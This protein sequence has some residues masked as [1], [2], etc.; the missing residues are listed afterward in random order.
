MLGACE[1]C[2]GAFTVEDG[3]EDAPLLTRF[4]REC[5]L[6][7]LE[8]MY[9]AAV[10]AIL[11]WLRKQGHERCWYY[12]DIFKEVMKAL[13]LTVDGRELDI[14]IPLVEFQKGCTTFQR[15]VYGEKVVPT[16]VGALPP[17]PEGHSYFWRLDM[18]KVVECNGRKLPTEVRDKVL[19]D[20]RKALA[21]MKAGDV[22]VHTEGVV[23]E[24]TA[25]VDQVKYL[26]CEDD[27]EGGCF[28]CT[29]EACKFC[30]TS[31][32]RD[33]QHGVLERHGA[34]LKVS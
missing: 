4:C 15:E 13:W 31:Y 11:L 25:T 6:S 16:V 34:G 19:Q 21:N 33:C 12:P 22:F 8:G 20:V 24:G 18:E 10:A 26:G 27:G 9:L 1:E 5:R 32:E 30:G 29:G 14:H 2:H 17:L 28:F 7:K 3:T 23:F